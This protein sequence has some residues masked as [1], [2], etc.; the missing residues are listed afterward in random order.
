MSLLE[1]K[2]LP[3]LVIVS[4]LS[5]SLSAA[6]YSVTGIGKMFSGSIISVMIMMGTLEIAKLILASMLYQYW[7]KFNILL[8]TYYF[9]AIFIL[10]GITS[11]G[12]YGFLSSAY[13]ETSNKVEV[14]DKSVAVLDI[15]R[16]LFQN[17]LDDIRTEK[18][19]ISDNITD[20]TKG[21]SNNTQQY[22]DKNGQILS[23]TSS[24]NRK[25]FESQLMSA[26]KR[27]DEITLKETQLTDSVSKIDLAKLNMQTD[28]GLAKEIGPLKYIAKI[29]N[30]PVDDVVNWFIIAL[31]LV[32]DPLAVSL[33][34]GANIIF[35]DIGGEKKPIEE[36]P[37]LVEDVEEE[38]RVEDSVDDEDIH[39]EPFLD[40]NDVEDIDEKQDDIAVDDIA[41]DDIA[42]D[43]I[44]EEL[45]LLSAEEL[46]RLDKEI[47]QW[48][49]QHWKMKRIP[50]P[51]AITD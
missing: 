19:R 24:G 28:A 34:V 32:F 38:E 43:D 18:Q 12:I 51:S 7:T 1:R 33:V 16:T 13:S 8:K 45:P 39:G 42:V 2:I 9:V 41:V 20:L 47:K 23:T 30:R 46:I 15:K 35:R 40:T 49:S 14:I 22:K 31:M 4:A 48:E 50:P 26:Q 11:A 3:Y 29:T 21:L 5:V 44:I 10:M 6:F 27:R 37:T 36:K 17:Q 25:A